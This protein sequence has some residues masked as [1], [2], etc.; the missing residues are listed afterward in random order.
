MR[1][2]DRYRLIQE[3]GAGSMGEVFKA[4]DEVMNRPVAIKRIHRHLLDETQLVERFKREAQ[5]IAKLSHPRIV[6]LYDFD[7]E[8]PDGPYLVTELLEGCTLHAKLRDGPMEWRSVV[9]IAVQAL[10]AL[11]F[12]HAAGLVHRDVKPGNIFLLKGSE[13]VKLLD[14]GVAKAQGAAG[15]LTEPGEII[16]TL[17]YAAPEQLRGEALDGR[18]DLY[19]LGAVMYRA[20]AGRR[21]FEAQGTAELVKAQLFDPPT[22]L[23]KLAPGVPA[24]LARLV[25]QAL[26]KSA[27]E[28]PSSAEQMRLQLNGLDE[29]APAEPW[30]E[31]GIAPLQAPA[32]RWGARRAIWIAGLSGA[33]SLAAL[34]TAGWSAMDSR[35]P[36][37]RLLERAPPGPASDAQ[38]AFDNGMNAF[39]AGVVDEAI[40]RMEEAHELDNA[41]A[42]ALL[43][44]AIWRIKKAP[45]RARSAYQRALR[46]TVSTARER[47]L[48]TATQPYMA[49]PWALKAWTDRLQEHLQR[50]PEDVE[51]RYY[52]ALSHYRRLEF[53]A[54]VQALDAALTL[55]GSWAVAYQLR[56][57]AFSMKGEAD[58]A[59][60]NFDRCLEHLPGSPTCLAQRAISYGR[61]GRCEAMREDARRLVSQA[62][63]DP[64]AHELLAASLHATGAPAQSVELAVSRSLSLLP[65]PRRER[66]ALSTRAR[67]SL[68][69]GKFK[70]A[71]ENLRVWLERAEH[72]TDQYRTAEPSLLLIRLL[73]E[74]GATQEAA[75][76]AQSILHKLISQAEPAGGKLSIHFDPRLAR[77]GLI[78]AQ[79]LERR[80]K[81]WLRRYRQ[82][83]ERAGR[84]TGSTF[85]W[86][87]WSTAYGAFAW[88][89]AQAKEAMSLMPSAP[90]KTVESGRWA[91]LDRNMGRVLLRA[92]EPRRALPHLQ[93]AAS[94]CERMDRPFLVPQS[95][96]LLGEALEQ[97]GQKEEAAKAYRAVLTAWGEASGSR[98]AKR[99]R[100]RL[101]DLRGLGSP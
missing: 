56:G 58:R 12:A 10:E 63:E 34:G 24:G 99:A 5:S 21:P 26:A 42:P 16:G 22:P 49:Q 3:V 83:W 65:E 86:I 31:R 82:K 6:Q 62:P 33:L 7:V 45:S 98:T 87:A 60:R 20:L 13:G 17:S 94:I 100:N 78:S 18:A 95:R 75:E 15:S 81:D 37:E 11:D 93:R 57:E 46:S 52:L 69:Q 92:G 38:R 79:E 77:G 39:R 70:R 72:E 30:K 19:A 1:L 53:D 88:S 68:A 90:I 89:P 28:R 14:F 40:Q 73:E 71:S 54:A 44:L 55:D 67:L 91:A 97:L 35:G 76:L 84:A 66:L 47:S 4:Y 25:H 2:A 48:L 74:R 101:Q 36:A 29:T 9:Q 61:V 64:R 96:L 80:R 51:A 23:T 8:G 27:E 59:L 41:F 85:D 50:Y 43:R 32:P